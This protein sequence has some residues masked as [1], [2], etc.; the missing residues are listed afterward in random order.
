MESNMPAPSDVSPE[1]DPRK[2]IPRYVSD[3]LDSDLNLVAIR[4][5]TSDRLLVLLGVQSVREQQKINEKLQLLLDKL[6]GGE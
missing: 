1:Y 4:C 3:C 6:D 2:V 5:S